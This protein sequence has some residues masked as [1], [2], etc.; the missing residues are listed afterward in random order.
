M[1]ES[2]FV[3]LNQKESKQMLELAK[4]KHEIFSGDVVKKADQFKALGDLTRLEILALLS[5]RDC[6]VC[7]LREALEGAASTVNH[8]L[9]LLERAGI[10]RSEKRGKYTIYTLLFTNEEIESILGG[11]FL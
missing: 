5:E 1:I 7:E 8:H 11:R 4:K 3:I 9:K 10:I 2:P 6:C